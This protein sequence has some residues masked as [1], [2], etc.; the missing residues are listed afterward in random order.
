EALLESELFGHAKGAFTDARTA[1]AGLFLQASGGTLFLDELG[2]MPLPLQAKL[3]RVLQERTVRP[4]G[5]DHEVPLDVRIVA[6]TNRDLEE[7][8]EAGRFRQDL[9]YRIHV[10][11]IELPPLR[12][13]GNDVL[14]LAQHALSRFATVNGRAVN[15]IAPAA[16]Q[17]LLAYDW[18]GNVRELNN[19]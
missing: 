8:I 4:V 9:Y 5:G 12:A 18:P 15:G 11:R 3:L 16:A 6:A 1:R 2:E 19:A 13:R 7:A 17:K 14:E 10:V